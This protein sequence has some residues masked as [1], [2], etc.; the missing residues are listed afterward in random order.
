[1]GLFEISISDE[2]LRSSKKGNAAVDLS[3]V[4]SITL[5]IHEINQTY[6]I[7]FKSKN[8]PST[9]EYAFFKIWRFD[10]KEHATDAW[11]K[12]QD[13]IT[14]DYA[15]Q[16][17][18]VVIHNE[19]LAIMYMQHKLWIK[20]MYSN[21]LQKFTDY[22]IDNQKDDDIGLMNDPDFDMWSLI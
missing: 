21:P 15:I 3:G 19:K 1:M 20:E 5:E 9:Q 4:R 16:F 10:T 17:D 13:I 8:F 2:I 18:S 7:G 11:Y 12:I 6:R 22:L 14:D